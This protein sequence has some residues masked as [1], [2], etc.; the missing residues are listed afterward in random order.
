VASSYFTRPKGL[1]PTPSACFPPPPRP[2]KGPALANF[3]FTKPTIT[4][5]DQIEY[6]LENLTWNGVTAIHCRAWLTMIGYLD[7]QEFQV[8]DDHVGTTHQFPQA[9]APSLL[10]TAVFVFDSGQIRTI[11]RLL[12]INP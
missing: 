2:K 8:P 3:W 7:N 4:M 5:A 9:P 10:C 1:H 6:N 11:K 12:T